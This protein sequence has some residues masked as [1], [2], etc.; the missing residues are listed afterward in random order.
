MISADD[1]AAI[2]EPSMACVVVRVVR[3]SLSL[4]D[5]VGQGF[6]GRTVE[7]NIAVKLLSSDDDHRRVN[8]AK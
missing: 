6:Q 4:V 7:L 3:F 8:W 1:K 2:I 5:E